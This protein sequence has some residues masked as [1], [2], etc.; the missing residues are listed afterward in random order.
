[1]MISWRSWSSMIVVGSMLAGCGP[2]PQEHAL[3][4]SRT[5]EVEAENAKLKAELKDLKFVASKL[6]EQ[7]RTLLSAG[8]LDEARAVLK[9][10]VKR[11]ELSP[12]GIEATALIAKLDADAAAAAENAEKAKQEAKAQAL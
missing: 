6:L 3:A 12:Q 7:G 11:H 2:S 9:D 8:K 5:A 1:M 10:L 4:L